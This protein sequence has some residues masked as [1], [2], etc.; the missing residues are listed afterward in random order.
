MQ[1]PTAPGSA[2]ADPGLRVCPQCGAVNGPT[3]AFCWQ[4]YRQFGG[5]SSGL[6]AAPAPTS[7]GAPGLRGVVLEP[8]PVAAPAIE[9]SGWNVRSVIAVIVA[10]ALLVAGVTLFLNR[11]PAVALPERFGGL[12]QAN[13]PQIDV[14]LDE[15]H[16]QVDGLGIQGDMGLYGNAAFPTVALVWVKD[17]TVASTDAAWD[18]FAEGFNQGLP[19]GSLDEAHRTSEL[20]GGVTYVCAPVDA[21]PPSNICLWEE[22]EVF[23]ILVDLSGASQ[24]GTRALAETARDAIAA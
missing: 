17:P 6:P 19:V 16:R 11:A 15:F 21:A 24:V 3:N 4:C 12:A 1:A 23:W 14:V 8:R 20:V 9:T 18:A 10:T 2:P 13:G 7:A 22:D 5:T